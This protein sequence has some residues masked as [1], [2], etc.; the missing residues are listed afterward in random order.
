MDCPANGIRN[1]YKSA[2]SDEAHDEQPCYSFVDPVFD[3][4]LRRHESYQG[5][6]SSRSNRKGSKRHS[7]PSTAAAMASDKVNRRR[8]HNNNQSEF[9]RP[10][11]SRAASYVPKNSNEGFLN[12]NGETRPSC[13][14]YESRGP[15]SLDVP[16]NFRDSQIPSRSS[17][18]TRGDATPHYSRIGNFSYCD[19]RQRNSIHENRSRIN[20]TRKSRC[21]A[22]DVA[23]SE[24]VRLGLSYAKAMVVE[25]L[26]CRELYN[27]ISKLEPSMAQALIESKTL[28]LAAVRKSRENSENQQP[29]ECAASSLFRASLYASM[30]IN[31]TCREMSVETVTDHL[32]PTRLS[33]PTERPVF[34]LKYKSIASDREPRINS[35]GQSSATECSNSVATNPVSA[36]VGVC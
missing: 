10:A 31:P 29:V 25:P 12:R 14:V 23:G 32:H 30:F 33:T 36:C 11:H 16:E 26:A 20:R 7:T 17:S 24:F 4:H 3:L 13:S 1:G 35:G 22:D 5:D 27:E 19:A 8:H 15:P 18:S 28:G 2:S 6:E 34:T 21:S 9:N